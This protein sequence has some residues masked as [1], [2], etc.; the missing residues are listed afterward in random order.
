MLYSYTN[1]DGT[2]TVELML[3]VAKM[4]TRK[5]IDG[6]W[7]YRDVV[8]DQVE[9]IGVGPG[10]PCHNDSMGVNPDQIPAAEAKLRKIGLETTYDRK[11]GCAILN[12]PKHYKRHAEALGYWSRNGGYSSPQRGAPTAADWD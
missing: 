5:K 8:A 4:T 12:S 11:T 6:E 10:W 2:K 1:K 3:P 7:Y 9:L